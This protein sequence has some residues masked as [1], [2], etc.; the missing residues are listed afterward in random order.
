MNSS[1]LPRRCLQTTAVCQ[2]TTAG[3]IKR[4]KGKKPVMYEEIS[5]P[6]TIGVSKGW[7]A[8]NTCKKNNIEYFGVLSLYEAFLKYGGHKKRGCALAFLKYGGHKR[9]G[10]ALVW[11]VN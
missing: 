5:P 8:H 11:V 6:Y 3:R 10:C 9:R 7:T 1:V 2:K 4:D